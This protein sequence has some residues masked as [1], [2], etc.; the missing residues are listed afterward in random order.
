MLMINLFLKGRD[1]VP[2]MEEMSMIQNEEKSLSFFITFLLF[3]YYFLFSYLFIVLSLFL[4]YSNGFVQNK[5]EF[6]FYFLIH[7]YLYNSRQKSNRCSK[8]CFYKC[9]CQ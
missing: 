9:L 5:S 3:N 1:K 7:L 6:L 4:F 8:G 2:L